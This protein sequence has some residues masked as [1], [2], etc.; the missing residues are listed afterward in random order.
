V[1]EWTT[2]RWLHAQGKSIRTIAKELGVARNT[3][4]AAVRMEQ[5]PHYQR[6]HRTNPKL[7]AFAAEI[8]QMVFVQ[9][10]NGS[11]ILRQLRARGYTGCN[12]AL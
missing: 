3:V 2:L 8:E 1:E 12:T 5:A 7:I 9:R 11:R 10:F 6:P 4:R